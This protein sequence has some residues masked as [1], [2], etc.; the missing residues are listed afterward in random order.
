MNHTFQVQGMTCGHCEMAVRK[1]VLHLD[2]QA[3]VEI[4][5]PHNKVEVESTHAREDVAHA[6]ADEGYQVA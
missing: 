5:R 1:S 3:K 2:P 4:D 6:I